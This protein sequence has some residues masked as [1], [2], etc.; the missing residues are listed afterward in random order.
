MTLSLK[1][2]S[3]HIGI[4]R[5]AVAQRAEREQWEFSLMSGLGGQRKL[6]ALKQLPTDVRKKI[7]KATLKKMLAEAPQPN[8]TKLAMVSGKPGGQLVV[9]N[10][11]LTL[12]PSVDAP[13]GWQIAT[14]EARLAILNE[15]ARLATSVSQEKAIASLID[16][17]QA[18]TLQ[19]HMLEVIATANARS[20]KDG[21]RTLSRRT[22]M[23]WK[24]LIKYAKTPEQSLNAL[25]PKKAATKGIP[26]WAGELLAYFQQP[27]KPSLRYA[28]EQIAANWDMPIDAFYHR[29]QRFV[30]KIGNVELEHGRRASRDLKN[31]KP[32]IRRSFENLLPGDVYQ[33]DGHCLDAEIAHPDHGRPFKPELT[34]IIDVASRKIVGVSVDLAE[35][36]LAVLDA[37]RNA[38]ELNSDFCVFY[39]DNGSAYHGTVV[40]GAMESAYGLSMASRL[41][42]TVIHTL[43]YNAKAKGIIERAH[44]SVWVRAAKMLPT[45][46]GA[47]MDRQVASNVH[48]I[49][50][51]DIKKAGKSKLLMSFEDFIVFAN[52]QIAQY[53]ARPHSTLGKIYD[54]ELDRQRHM[55]PDD[56]WQLGIAKNA[57]I[58]RIPK[59]EARDLFRPRIERTVARGEINLF[60]NWYFSQELKEHHGDVVQVAYDVNNA[61]SVLVYTGEGRFICEAKFEGNKRDHFPRTVIEQARAKRGN[62]RLKRND[63]HR[64]EIL[65]EMAGPKMRD[66]TPANLEFA[67]SPTINTLN[68]SE[69]VEF[70]EV[71]Q[72]QGRPLFLLDSEKYRWLMKNQSECTDRDR[73]WLRSFVE[74]DLYHDLAERFADEG[75]AWQQNEQLKAI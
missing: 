46:I 31:I 51:D 4:S 29:A 6:F 8:V 58:K 44:K 21:Q 47:S 1:E 55:S 2:I 28:C 35:S 53:N 7:E 74:G 23:G 41:G 45:Y 13:E 72:V 34:V 42:F 63:A 9:T 27:Q 60:T 25:L 18:G 14:A 64:Q 65:E 17:A 59:E 75:L 48:K 67:P 20:G 57:D 52:E 73:A 30:A 11:P 70:A 16:G 68:I 43:P 26:P 62:A 22:I 71:P 3:S 5:Q 10:S 37:M 32:F 66:I 24:D 12:A 69:E 36:G 54:P 15:I 56:A 49:T 61:E 19:P 33:A 40:K 38:V 50:R 39:V